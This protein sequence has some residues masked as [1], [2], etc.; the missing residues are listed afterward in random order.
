MIIHYTAKRMLRDTGP[1]LVM[2]LVSTAADTFGALQQQVFLL[3]SMS[4]CCSVGC[5]VV[6]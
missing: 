3:F 1:L 5:I 6:Q 4:Y 2:L